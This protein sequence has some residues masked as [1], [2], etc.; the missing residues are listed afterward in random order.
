MTLVITTVRMLN[1]HLEDEARRR[2]RTAGLAEIVQLHVVN[3]CPLDLT[4]SQ[5][6]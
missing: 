4:L 2:R 6:G 3:R 1:G 5:H